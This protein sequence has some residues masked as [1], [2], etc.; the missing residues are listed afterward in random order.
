MPARSVVSTTSRADGPTAPWPP[1]FSD[2]ARSGIVGC[3]STGSATERRRSGTARH[4]SWAGERLAL[5]DRARR[6][7]ARGFVRGAGRGRRRRAWA[8]GCA[9]IAATD[10]RVGIA[11]GPPTRRQRRR[12]DG[13]DVGHRRPIG[14]RRA[15]AAQHQLV[16]AD[17]DLVPL[18]Q[19]RRRGDLR[20]V[21]PDAGEAGEILDVERAVLAR[22]A[23]V[24]A[25]DVPLGQ[26]DGVPLQPTDGH[27]VPRERNDRGLTLIVFDA[28]LEH[29]ETLEITGPFDCIRRCSAG[30]NGRRE[31]AEY[32]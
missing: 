16:V 8:A 28:Q 6:R 19:R 10:A 31:A 25:R 14:D 3:P 29:G 11:T 18:A 24:L 17:L 5:R 4:R 1:G 2:S 15:V 22:E 26:P 9:A 30:V 20:A 32:G 21:D 12:G 13:R 27:L 23:R 7:R